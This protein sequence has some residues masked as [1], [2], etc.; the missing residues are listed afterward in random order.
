MQPEAEQAVKN[1]LPSRGDS[2]SFLA[3]GPWGGCA[4]KLGQLLLMLFKVCSFKRGGK[5]KVYFPEFSSGNFNTRSNVAEISA[6]FTTASVK[7]KQADL[8]KKK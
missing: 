4:E 5:K 6:C 8:K 3:G 7:I 2:L 1:G